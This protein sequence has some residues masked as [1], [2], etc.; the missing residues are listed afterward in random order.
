M[1]SDRYFTISYGLA[2]AVLVVL[3]WICSQVVLLKSFTSLEENS[4]RKNVQVVLN[5]LTDDLSNLNSIATHFATADDSNA[6]IQ[7]SNPRYIKENLNALTFIHQRLNVILFINTSGTIV[8]SRGFDLKEQKIVPEIAGLQEHLKH[9][10]LLL[11]YYKQNKSMT[12]ILALP[13]GPMF[14]SSHP[15]LNS[16]GKGSIKGML[17]MGRYLT[18]T[19]IAQLSQKTHLDLT[20]Q[21]FRESQALPKLDLSLHS[22]NRTRQIVVEP[23]GSDS[24]SG[25]TLIRD[26]YNHPAYVV[27][28]KRDRDISRY[29][30]KTIHF[31]MLLITGITLAFGLVI[32]T[33]FHKLLLSRQAHTESENRYCT[34]VEQ[35]AEGIIL[36][37]PETRR[38]LQTN[39][40][41]Q[42]LLGYSP[43][44]L[45]ELTLDDIT[46]QHPEYVEALMQQVVKERL[47]FTGE[48]DYM[49]LDT[50]QRDVE[51]CANLVSYYGK[52]AICIVA[53][54]I[55]ERK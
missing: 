2:V 12:G 40:A 28:V 26:L 30:R 53:H 39:G 20:F 11:N 17:L 13:K 29:G 6:F 36:V 5:T 7:D 34:I 43:E 33:V 3:L 1:N 46:V 23:S 14:I 19:E 16:E 24:I 38:F 15:V 55:T 31:F 41:F 25:Y 45:S 27:K 47:P 8:F 37:D 10:S 49:C 4:V 42:N 54:Y 35:A 52:E 22:F 48:Q 44:Q 50:S 21:P 32:K 51:L 9:G 18:P